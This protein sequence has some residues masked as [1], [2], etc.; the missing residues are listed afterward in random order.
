MAD[1]DGRIVGVHFRLFTEGWVID[2]ERVFA[3]AFESWIIAYPFEA[4]RSFEIFFDLEYIGQWRHRLFYS[5]ICY[6]LSI[7]WPIEYPI[8]SETYR[9]IY[10][11]SNPV[12]EQG[13]YTRTQSVSICAN[14]VPV[15]L[16]CPN[17]KL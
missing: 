16:L 9:V 8:E 10:Y 11:Q 3:G 1:S 12:L 7:V 14:V 2:F 15:E 4:D 13:L 5:I 6:K 17:V